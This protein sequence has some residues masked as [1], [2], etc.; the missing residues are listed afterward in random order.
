[1]L[2]LGGIPQAGQAFNTAR[3]KGWNESH[4]DDC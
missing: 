2:G 3:L 1:M 4:C